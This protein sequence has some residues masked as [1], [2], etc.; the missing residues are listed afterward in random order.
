MWLSIKSLNKF[1]FLTFLCAFLFATNFRITD[2][3]KIQARAGSPNSPSNRL[4]PLF[5]KSGN[6]PKCSL[7]N[8]LL[9][10]GCVKS[11]SIGDWRRRFSPPRP[12]SICLPDGNLVAQRAVSLGCFSTTTQWFC[13]S[14]AIYNVNAE[15][16]MHRFARGIQ[17]PSRSN[18]CDLQLV[19]DHIVPE[20]CDGNNRYLSVPINLTASERRTWRDSSKAQGNAPRLYC[21]QGFLSFLSNGANGLQYEHSR[22]PAELFVLTTHNTGRGSRSSQPTQHLQVKLRIYIENCSFH[23]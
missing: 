16:L 3:L 10:M 9:R 1:I 4:K 2:T 12:G 6:R 14:V 23:V 13:R 17:I 21:A 20:L 8:A 18:L 22:F 5:I 7:K 19:S 11:R 15:Q